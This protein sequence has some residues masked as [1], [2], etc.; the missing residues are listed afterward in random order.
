[1]P[2]ER[3]KML[4]GVLYDPMDPDLV[5]GRERARDLCAALNVTREAEQSERRR[6][7]M[8]LFGAGGDSVWMQPPFFC[9]YG[10]NIELG[11]RVFFNFNCIV[12]DA[13][14]TMS[15]DIP[16]SSRWAIG[17]SSISTASF[18]MFAPFASVISLCSG[19]A[20]RSSLPCI[21]STQP[22]ADGRNAASRCR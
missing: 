22:C 20:F 8:E 13:S 2:S 18:W 19:R 3:E 15:Y 9:D 4:A 7:L 11:E 14:V 17:C 12:L 21:L 1:M 5:A 6:I 16:T 10:S